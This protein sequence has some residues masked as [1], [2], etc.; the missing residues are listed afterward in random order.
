MASIGFI[1]KRLAM[2]ANCKI[3]Y[4]SI[5]VAFKMAMQK[6]NHDYGSFAWYLFKHKAKIIGVSCLQKSR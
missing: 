2:L 6:I 4:L 3:W 1:L 5:S